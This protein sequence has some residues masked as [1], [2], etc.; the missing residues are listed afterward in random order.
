MPSLVVCDLLRTAIEKHRCVRIIAGG[1]WRDISPLSLGY[2]GG[3]LKVL[4]FQFRGESASGI[5]AE[6]GW[7]C[8]FVD[9]ISWAK[10]IDD[11]WH[12]GHYPVAK[13]EASLDSVICGAGA[14]VRSFSA[15]KPH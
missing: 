5:A 11:A 12:T 14:T 2:K 13:I 9:D 7:R 15:A 6:G 8:F 4:A 10:L 3:K 1:H